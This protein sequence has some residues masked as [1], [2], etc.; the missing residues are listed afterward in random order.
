VD[1]YVRT[2]RTGVRITETYKWW[3]W[4]FFLYILSDHSILEHVIPQIF[5]ISTISIP[6]IQDIH[7]IKLAKLVIFCM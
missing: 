6:R 2:G 4:P 7:C 5:R 1:V 3:N